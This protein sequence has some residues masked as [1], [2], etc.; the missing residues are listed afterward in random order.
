[1]R[2]TERRRDPR[3]DNAKARGSARTEA[4]PSAVPHLLSQPP[5]AG[6]RAEGSPA[7]LRRAQPWGHLW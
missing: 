1:M 7:P 5:R 4:V 2:E 6:R 3:Y